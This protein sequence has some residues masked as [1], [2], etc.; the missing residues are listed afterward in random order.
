MLVN[1][2]EGTCQVC[3]GTLEVVDADDATMT[4][5]CTKCGETYPVEPDAFGDGCMDYYVP[6]YSRKLNGED[7]LNHDAL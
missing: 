7:E 5:S 1:R 6:F 4:V 3:D 2:N